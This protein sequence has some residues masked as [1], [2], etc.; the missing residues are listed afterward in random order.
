MEN[1]LNLNNLVVDSSGNVSFS[2]LTSGIDFANVVEQ[3]IAAKQIPIDNLQVKIDDNDAIAAALQELKVLLGDL[4][5]ALS[6]LQGTVSVGGTNNTFA[7]KQAFA[8]TSRADSNTPSLAANLIGVSV[9]SAAALGSHT[10]EA[11]QIATA[12]K[13]SSDAFTS[14]STAITGLTDSAS[15]TIGLT[16]G[17]SATINL[18]SSDTLLDIRDKI[19]NANTGTNATKVTASIVSVGTTENYLVITADETGKDLILTDGTDTP[20]NT[21]GVLDGASIK[22]ELQAAQK[23]RFT[24]DGILD[25]SFYHSVLVA[26]DTAAFNSY[27]SVTAGS[28]SFEIRDA[29]GALVGT[30]N[31]DDTDNLNDLQATIDAISGVTAAVVPDSGQFRLQITKDDG[32]AITLKNDTDN[33][34]AGLN[35]TKPNLKVLERDSNTISDLFP[36][37]TLTLFQAEVGTTI[38]IDVERDLSAVKTDIQDFIDNYNTV[39]EFINKHSQV[40]LSTGTPAADAI[41]FGSTT[42]SQISSQIG[43]IVGRGV[44][45]VDE[46]FS[47]L[48]QIGITFETLNPDNPLDANK[49]ILNEAELDTALL[50]NPDDVRRLFAFNFTSS[51]PNVSLLNFTGTTSFNASGYTLNVDFDDRYK[52]SAITT[53]TVYTP[54]YGVTGIPASNG[55]SQ[56]T[57]SDEVISGEAF[58][59]SYDSAT[60]NFTIVNLA[61]GVSSTV[62]V[63]SAIDAVA[64]TGNNLGA[65]ETVDITFPETF[66]TLTLTGD[67]TAFDRNADIATDVNADT[68]AV[69]F[70][71]FGNVTNANDTNGGIT[72][73]TLQ[74]L[75]SGA[76]A[77]SYDAATGLLSLNIT[78]DGAGSTIFDTTAGVTFVLDAPY[79]GSN[80]TATTVDIEDGGAHTVGIVVNGE[81]I[82]VVSLDA[83]TSTG[84]GT[85]AITIDIGTGFFAE[86]SVVTDKDAPISN[87]LAGNLDSSFQILDSGGSPVPGGTINYASTDSLQDIATAINNVA[88]ISAVIFEENGTFHIDILADDSTELSFNDSGDLISQLAVTKDLT[89]GVKSATINGVPGSA[90]VS[91]ATITATNLTGAEGLQI[92]FSGT[93]DVSSIS[94]NFTVGIGAQ[95]HAVL[96]SALDL[97][98]GALEVEVDGIQDQ[99]E[100]TED[101]IAEQLA[102]LER[103]RQTL[104]ARFIAMETALASMASIRDSITLMM[105]L[106]TAKQ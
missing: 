30:V 55:I 12:H 47:V 15:F 86:T 105:D 80:D 56:V 46:A 97:T 57:F 54:S 87:Y 75:L 33:L 39:R 81:E 62:N 2:G 59:Y 85:N 28:H 102:R 36:G 17:N 9:T 90:T 106:I 91:G 48:R 50:N 63:T 76:A 35:F 73:P 58:R 66:I 6:T 31:Y 34:L 61:T 100:V 70:V 40:D 8:T 7:L 101:R 27:T 65:G 20:L 92:L 52:S 32:T 5:S 13:V 96:D 88:G 71:T 68:S 38:K 103:Q 89:A 22:T 24:A 26:D 37:V 82:A 41:L 25:S 79:N 93:D 3:I 104:L 18:S 16:G 21:L 44:Q 99:N 98:N 69:A 49:L 77:A 1:S 11:Q 10:L 51:D 94:L 42:L 60:E 84:A 14:T 95:M 67:G 19:N 64:G 45:G 83:L 78:S 29:S 74:D 43:G 72:E 23:A 4:R 53:N